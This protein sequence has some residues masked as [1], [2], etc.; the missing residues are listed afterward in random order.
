MV[1]H[2]FVNNSRVVVVVCACVVC[3]LVNLGFALAPAG[4]PS[5]GTSSTTHWHIGNVLQYNFS[6]AQ[7]NLNCRGQVRPS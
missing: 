1:T 4:A 2:C 6:A 5:F 7:H 3:D